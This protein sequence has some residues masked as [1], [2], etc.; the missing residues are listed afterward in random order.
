[1]GSNWDVWKKIGLIG[2]KVFTAAREGKAAF[3]KSDERWTNENR[4]NA[5]A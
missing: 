3:L 2:R 5:I 4:H 1:M